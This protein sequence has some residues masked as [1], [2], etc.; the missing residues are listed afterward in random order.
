VGTTY[1]QIRSVPR[2]SQEGFKVTVFEPAVGG[3]KLTNAV[4][5][6]ASGLLSIVAPL[7]TYRV[8]RGGGESGH[9]EADPGAGQRTW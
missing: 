2:R 4:E 1:R 3:T 5:L 6:R 8:K 7:A 9:P